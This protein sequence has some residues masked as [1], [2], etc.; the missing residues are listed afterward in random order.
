[1]RGDLHHCN[2]ICALSVT[3]SGETFTTA[4]KSK[5]QLIFIRCRNNLIPKCLTPSSNSLRSIPTI[6]TSSPTLKIMSTNRSEGDDYL[7]LGSVDSYG[8]LIVS[9]LD[10]DGKG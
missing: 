6:L 3:K 8:H 10:N 2:C 7:I 1:M 9:R 5:G 4:T